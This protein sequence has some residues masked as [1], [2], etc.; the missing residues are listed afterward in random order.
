MSAVSRNKISPARLH[1]L[2]SRDFRNTAADHCLKCKV[3]MPMHFNSPSGGA[4]W[5]LGSG[6]ECSGLC[7]TILEEIAAKLAARYDVTKPR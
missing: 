1:E 2:L 4:N 7:H 3:P 6:A 5:R